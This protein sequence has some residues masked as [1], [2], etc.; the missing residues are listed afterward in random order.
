MVKR[1][2][3]YCNNFLYLYMFDMRWW[4]ILFLLWGLLGV[5]CSSSMSETVDSVRQMETLSSVNEPGDVY[6]CSLTDFGNKIEPEQVEDIYRAYESEQHVKN[7]ILYS[8][9]LLC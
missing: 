2:I 6:M 7:I 9:Y 8:V 1:L 4:A 5:P 3:N